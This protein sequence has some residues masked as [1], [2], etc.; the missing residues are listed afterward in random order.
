MYLYKPRG[1]WSARS[2]H[3]FD[4]KSILLVRGFIENTCSGDGTFDQFFSAERL[5]GSSFIVTSFLN[6]L[7]HPELTISQQHVPAKDRAF[8]IQSSRPSKSLPEKKIFWGKWLLSLIFF[9]F[10]SL[11]I[12]KI[13][14]KHDGDTTASKLN[15][16]L[17]LLTLHAMSGSVFGHFSK[18]G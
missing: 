16:S 3:G 2:R 11:F 17:M 7:R 15:L 13:S 10:L 5:R 6:P 18:R 8:F 9:F 4:L 1:A 12:H 14:L